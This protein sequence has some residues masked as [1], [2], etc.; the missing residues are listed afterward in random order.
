MATSLPRLR[1]HSKEL[2]NNIAVARRLRET[3]AQENLYEDWK[4]LVKWLESELRSLSPALRNWAR[5]WVSIDADQASVNIEHDASWTFG[6]QHAV[7]LYFSVFP[8]SVFDDD[9][10]PNVGLW[11]SGD[12]EHCDALRAVLQTRGRPPG[13]VSTY[14]DGTT[15]PDCPFWKPLPL[16]GFQNEGTF[17]LERLV[18][19]IAAAF[20]SLAAVRSVIDGYLAEHPKAHPLVPLLRKALILDLETWGPGKPDEDE[21]VEVGLI[22]TAYDSGSGEL[23]GVLDRYEGLRDPGRRATATPSGRLTRQMVAGERLISERVEALIAQSDVIISHNAFGFDK[24]RF[25]R[26]FPSTKSRP[27]LCSCRGLSWSSCGLDAANLEHLCERLGVKNRE[28]HRA[29]PDADTLLQ[30]LA[31]KH[32]AISYF[33]E[34]IGSAPAD[35][36]GAQAAAAGRRSK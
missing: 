25:E 15:D 21:I 2:L 10:A 35:K 33:A 16:Q 17:D 4:R 9:Y 24:P 13:F 29:M 8:E 1:P 6:G 3:D 34:L 7:C 31:Q 19:E 26:L 36:V 28:A 32:G 23:V 12:W 27:W 18:N 20:E 30:I 5:P 11:I 14:S 22:L